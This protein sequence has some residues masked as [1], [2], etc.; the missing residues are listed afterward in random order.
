[1]KR[2]AVAALVAAI[3]LASGTCALA[4]TMSKAEY[5][6]ARKN[7]VS[8]FK[9]ARTGCEPM[10]GNVNDLCLVDVGGR[11]AIALAELEA[12]YLP[13]VRTRQDAH[14]AKAEAGYALALKKCEY[15][16]APAKDACLKDAA[17]SH[18]AAR[19]DPDVQAK[20]AAINAGKR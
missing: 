11:E 12:A 13:S 17:A 14:I 18:V 15:T 4:Q 16:A 19:A 10:L 6:V 8:D 3:G 9:G 7:I 2:R 20:A 1:V 5:L